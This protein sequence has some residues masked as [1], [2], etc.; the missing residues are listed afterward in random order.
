MF[1]YLHLK[2]I[3]LLELLLASRV[4]MKFSHNLFVKLLR[5]PSTIKMCLGTM[6]SMT[7]GWELWT[8][9]LSVVHVD[10]VW[11]S[12]TVTPGTSPFRL[13]CTMSDSLVQFY[14]F[15]GLFVTFVQNY[16]YHL[17]NSKKQISNSTFKN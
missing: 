10:M 14:V 17:N 6:Q 8:D 13:H 11:R 1:V 2:I 15:F 3:I 5:T 7:Y 16:W 12:A 9:A 4:Q